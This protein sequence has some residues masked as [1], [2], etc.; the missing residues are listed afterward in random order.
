[1]WGQTR[2][3]PEESWQGGGE[4]QALWETTFNCLVVVR[5]CPWCQ[6]GLGPNHGFAIFTSW[7]TLC[8]NIKPWGPH[9]FIC[10]M[11]IKLVIYSIIITVVKNFCSL[12]FGK[13]TLEIKRSMEAVRWGRNVNKS[14]KGRARERIL[15]RMVSS[16]RR[17]S[18][19]ILKYQF[20]GYPCFKLP[21]RMPYHLW[22]RNNRVR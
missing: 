20:L 2:A 3:K 10:N 13:V 7:V 4:G 21:E 18:L 9:F 11:G 17:L 16:L 22:L 5:G 19:I 14:K 1:M 12:R 6:T 8:K 15:S